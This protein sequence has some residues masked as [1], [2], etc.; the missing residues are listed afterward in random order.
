MATQLNYWV[1]PPKALCPN[2]QRSRRCY[3]SP[4]LDTQSLGLV[5]G[6]HNDSA[7]LTGFLLLDWM[8]HILSEQSPKQRYLHSSTMHVA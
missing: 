8:F 6:F 2:T 1:V 5:S 7:A 3:T 4:L